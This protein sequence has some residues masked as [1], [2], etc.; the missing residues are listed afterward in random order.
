MEAM[1]D[2]NNQQRIE[3]SQDFDF[4]EKLISEIK[5]RPNLYNVRSKSYKDLVLKNNLWLEIEKETGI[6]VD[7]LKKRWK[8]IRDYYV[9]NKKKLPTGSAA[10]RKCIDMQRMDSLRFLEGT[11]ILKNETLSNVR[12]STSSENQHDIGL[13]AEGDNESICYEDDDTPQDTDTDQSLELIEEG[14]YVSF[15]E[16]SKPGNSFYNQSST[17]QKVSK[18]ER[19]WQELQ[20]SRKER[21]EILK[22][23]LKE[24]EDEI[25][26]FFKSIAMTVKSF[27]ERLQVDAKRKIA[28]MIF[29]LEEENINN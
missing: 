15:E 11:Y 9:R 25:D 28:N 8:T 3:I 16:T 24:K 6:A 1:A 10:K 18:K 13:I 17:R 26:V 2:N 20:A 19:Y 21:T 4:E 22:S 23:L 12:A 7:T 29:D 27:P 5:K 14:N